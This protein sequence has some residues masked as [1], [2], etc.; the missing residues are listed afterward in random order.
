M[1]AP[2][3]GRT[4]RDDGF[5]MPAEWAPHQATL[6][7]WPNRMRADLWGHL[8][9]D[10]EHDYATVANA[11]AAFEPVIMVVDPAQMTE[12]RERL[13]DD[14]ELLPVL[15]DDSWIR[16]SGPIFVTDGRGDVALVHFGFN[17]WGERYRPY[18]HDARVP[19]AIAAHLGMR[20]Y[21]APMILEGG[22]ICVDGE[23]TLLTTETCNLNPNRNP[24]MTAEQIDAVLHDYLGAEVVVWLPYGWSASR[25]TDGHVDGI[26]LFTAAGTAMLLAPADPSDPDHDRGLAN[27]EVIARTPDARGRTIEVTPFDPGAPVELTHLNVYLTNGGG[28]IVPV[29]DVPEDEVALAQIRAAMPDREVV[30]V[31]GVVL[32]EGGGGPHCITQQVPAGTAVA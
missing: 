15:I 18:D 4:P 8:F 10:A 12:A 26:A 6:M 11:I 5:S 22:S 27:A 32:H 21:V 9:A 30:P 1:T 28:V 14:I 29:G 25:D 16:D 20:R 17:G 31:P 19:Q 7:A 23:G 13:R 24:S 3:A 2:I